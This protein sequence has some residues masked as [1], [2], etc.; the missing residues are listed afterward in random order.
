MLTTTFASL[1][2]HKRRLLAMCSAVLLG[3]AFLSGTLVLG[4][5]MDSTFTDLFEEANAGTDAVVRSTTRIESDGMNQTGLLDASLGDRIAGTDGVTAVAPLIER[6]GQIV[7]ADGDPLGGQ[8]PPTV[9]GNWITD[10]QLNPY[11][12]VDGRAPESGNE[13]VIDKKSS[14]DGDLHIGDHAVVR[15]PQPIDVDI[16]GIA[17]FGDADSLGGS[18]YAAFTLDTAQHLLLPQPGQVTSFIVGADDGVTQTALVDDLQPLLPTGSEAITGHALTAEQE[19][20]VQSDFLGVFKTFLLVFAGIALIVATFSIYNTFAIVVA[21]KTRESALLR[22]LGASRRQILTAV[23]AEALVVGIVASALGVVAG[24]GLAEGLGSLLAALG[25]DLP[26]SSLVIEPASV[27]AALTVGLVVT[28]LASVMP[29][30]RASKVPP[31]AALRDVAVDRSAAS[32]W[33]AVLGLLVIGGGAAV[34]VGGSSSGTL[35]LTGLG[36]LAMVFG[37][38]LVGPV[39]ARPIAGLLG[40]PMARLRGVSGGLARRNA[41]R[42]PRRTSST[43]TALLVGVAVVAMFTVVASSLKAYVDDST[44]SA[45]QGDLVLVSDSFSGVSLSPQLAG[46]IADLP[47][48]ETAT[49]LGSAP[50]RIDGKDFLATTADGPSLAKVLDVGVTDGAL[51]DLGPG[52]VA[53][54]DT[55]AADHGWKLGDTVP[56]A[57]ADGAHQ[58][59]RVSAVYD[60]NDLVDDVVVARETYAPHAVQ[61]DDYVVMID[62]APGVDLHDGEAAVQTVA[63]RYY[64]P[65]VQD[66]EEYVASVAAEIDQMLA[67]VYA[68]LVLAIVIALMGIANTLSLSM[69]ERTRELGLLRAVGQS[70]RQL[71][72]M[73]RGESFVV[74]LFGTVGG[75]GLG[76]FLGWALTQAIG[77]AEDTSMPFALPIGQMAVV[78]ALGALVGVAAAVRPARRAAKLDVLAAIATD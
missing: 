6:A 65:D 27:A 33:R 17:T 38:V 2:G 59:L 4:D 18:T 7:G 42:N 44:A 47:E 45:F 77:E 67:L 26:R 62:L 23:V 1:R 13:V 21:Q 49:A 15:V 55:Y 19:D 30:R 36:A 8:G 46:A 41:M 73:V 9:A 69:H 63:D 37:M 40:A 50:M 5:T 11:Q 53:L 76:G 66:R 57:Y 48:V 20:A 72:S 24:I 56:V 51:T 70:R 74:A 32:R 68:L 29:A 75:L 31:L 35:G 14:E 22:A 28:V 60:T 16:V 64:A 25:M 54:S 71:R 78:L 61:L 10:E 12:L 58:D 34:T 52:M 39:V 3:V 43:A